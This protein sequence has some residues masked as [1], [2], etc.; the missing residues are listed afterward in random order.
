M[1]SMA[2]RRFAKGETHLR[3]SLNSQDEVMARIQGFHSKLDIPPGASAEVPV[4]W[5]V[6][7]RTQWPSVRLQAMGPGFAESRNFPQPGRPGD[8]QDL[9]LHMPYTLRSLYARPYYVLI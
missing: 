7:S 5:F 6:Y 8:V 2:K 1:E 4:S 9:D 3:L